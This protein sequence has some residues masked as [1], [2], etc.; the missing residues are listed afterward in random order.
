MKEGFLDLYCKEKGLESGQFFY[1]VLFDYQE[2]L[3]SSYNILFG[4][5]DYG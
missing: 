2:D 4:I 5:D 3:R 1:H